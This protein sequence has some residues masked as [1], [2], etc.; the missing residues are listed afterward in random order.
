[1]EWKD[2]KYHVAWIDA[3]YNTLYCTIGNGGPEKIKPPIISVGSNAL[4]VVAKRRT[5]GGRTQFYYIKKEP[6]GSYPCDADRTY[7]PFD[8][9]QFAAL[10]EELDLPPFEKRFD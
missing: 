9:A 8:A 10:R 7:G 6:D 3:G 4:F 5:E 1:M 2:E